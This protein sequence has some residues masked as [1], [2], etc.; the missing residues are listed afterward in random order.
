M[1]SAQARAAASAAL[2]PVPPIQGD[3]KQ[4][5]QVVV[6]IM[7]NAGQAIGHAPGKIAVSLSADGREQLRLSVADSGCG[8]DEAT[9]ARVFEPFFTTK[10][11]GEGTGLGL[12]ISRRLARLMGGEIWVHSEAGRGSEFHFTAHLDFAPDRPD[13]APPSPRSNRSPAALPPATT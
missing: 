1:S 13:A 4:L 6:N 8:M 5:Q 7:T 2:S 12:A 9:K 11:K 3:A 10:E